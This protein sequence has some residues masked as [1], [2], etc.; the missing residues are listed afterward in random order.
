MKALSLGIFVVLLAVGAECYKI[1]GVFPT[2][3]KSHWQIGATVM[4]QLAAAGH[5][6]TIVSP[7]ELKEKN[8]RNVILTNYPRGERKHFCSLLAVYDNL[9]R[10]S[11]PNQNLFDFTNMAAVMN[12]LICADAMETSINFTLSHP[13]FQQLIQEKFDLVIVELFHSEALLGEVKVSDQS[14]LLTESLQVSG[15]ILTVQ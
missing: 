1:L 3:W 6:V 10:F 12:F 8:V 15:S 2:I 5:D 14:S 9:A 11:D 4:K 7:F 13:N